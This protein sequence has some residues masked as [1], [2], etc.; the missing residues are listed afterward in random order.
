MNGAID[1]IYIQARRVLLDALDALWDHHDAL[2]LVGAQAIYLHTGDADLAVAPFTSDADLAINPDALKPEPK[3]TEALEKAGFY[4]APNAIGIWTSSRANIN[5]DL[6]VPEAIASGGRRSVDLGV[7]GNRVAR[8]VRGLEPALVDNALMEI[9]ALEPDDPRHL[10]LRVAGPAALMVAKLHKLAERKDQPD[11]LKDKDAL[12][13]YRLLQATDTPD[14]AAKITFLLVDQRSEAITR[15]A[16][17]HLQDL[18]GSPNSLGSA[19]AG[20]AV[21]LVADPITIAQ[22][23]AILATDLLSVIGA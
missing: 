9:A 1:P 2:L 13:I 23:A 12:D 21:E 17:T 16:I 18:F 7:H 3:L 6:L 14:L 10:E 19:M 4:T 11:R 15:Q 22:S 5:T 20:R 8:K